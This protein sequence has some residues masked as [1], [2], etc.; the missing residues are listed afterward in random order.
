MNWLHLFNRPKPVSCSDAGKL[1]AQVK[2]NREAEKRRAKLNELLAEQGKP[3]MSF[4]GP[5]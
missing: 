2:A 4:G 5:A 3:P 1:G